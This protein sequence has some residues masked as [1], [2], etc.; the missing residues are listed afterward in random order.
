M[1]GWQLKWGQSG[2]GRLLY[3]VIYE[4]SP[5]G[6]KEAMQVFGEEQYEPVCGHQPPSLGPGVT[7]GLFFQ[8][9]Q[10]QVVSANSISTAHLLPSNL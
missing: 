8:F 6:N 9:S 3:E 5:E 2:Q 10:G 1:Q 4:Q 7:P